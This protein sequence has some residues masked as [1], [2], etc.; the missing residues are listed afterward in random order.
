MLKKNK[1]ML[2]ITTIVLL[3]PIVVG[4]LLW[5]QLPDDFIVFWNAYDE[6]DSFAPRA[7]GVFALP[8][9]MLLIHWIGIL[10]TAIDPRNTDIDGRSVTVVLWICPVINLLLCGILF[11]QAAGYSV[12]VSMFLPMLMGIL[13]LFIGN[14]MPK[15]KRNYTIG[16]KV[17]WA[18]E[19]EKNWNATHRFAG[20]VWVIGGLAMIALPWLQAFWPIADPRQVFWS[21]VSFWGFWAMILVLA[22]IPTVYSYRYYR[23]HKQD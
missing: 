21:A 9:I 11:V 1:V 4:I 3:L 8:G 19:D 10:I 7:V 13:F 6:G 22:L 14:Y 5:D 12:H 16:I 18:L 2:I 15:C 23:K 17:P 20:K